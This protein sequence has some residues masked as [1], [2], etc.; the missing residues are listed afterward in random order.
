MRTRIKHNAKKDKYP[1]LMI[2]DDAND[3]ILIKRAFRKAKIA[4]PIYVVENGE[5]AIAYLAGRE[6]YCARDQFPLPSLVLLDL[7]LPRKSGHEVMA[8]MRRQ[9]G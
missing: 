4:N 6:K 9:P 7:K 3:I 1:I 8:W 2:E 5:E